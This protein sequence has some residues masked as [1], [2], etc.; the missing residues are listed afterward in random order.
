[1]VGKLGS[2]CLR[3]GRFGVRSAFCL[4]FR[5]FSAWKC[6]L[7]GNLDQVSHRLQVQVVDSAP[8]RLHIGLVRVD[9]R[10][11]DRAI[12][13]LA[14]ATHL[15]RRLITHRRHLAGP[16]IPPFQATK[17]PHPGFP[18]DRLII[19]LPALHL[20]RILLHAVQDFPGRHLAPRYLFPA[21]RTHHESTL[22]LP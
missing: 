14:Q 9:T 19:I 2:I 20:R 13:H 17:G 21:S 4:L 3:T 6:L 22:C 15:E 1:M 16:A 10:R 18:R 8:L 5:P 11:L 7:G 12:H